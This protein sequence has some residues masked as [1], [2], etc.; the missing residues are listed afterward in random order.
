MAALWE[1]FR[2]MRHSEDEGSRLGAEWNLRVLSEFAGLPHPD[3]PS[4]Y[5][6]YGVKI[7]WALLEALLSC[8]SRYA[9]FM[10][11]DLFRRTERFNIPGTVG[12]TNWRIRMPFTVQEMSSDP[13]LQREAT[14]L[15]A[16]IKKTKR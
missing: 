2:E 3:K 16:L 11:T 6:K 7:Q 1:E 10:I 5:R 8:N 15:K 13:A 9:A 14:K 4:G 12:N